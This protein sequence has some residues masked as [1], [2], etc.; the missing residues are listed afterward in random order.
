MPAP[1]AYFDTSVL[2]KRYVEEAGSIDAAPLFRQFQVVSS[3]LAPVEM[4]SALF[5]R[6]AAG[7]LIPSHVMSTLTRIQSERGR[8][9]LIQIDTLALDVVRVG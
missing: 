7:E 6:R 2:M 4:L 3:T 5:R 9:R 8:W 1:Q